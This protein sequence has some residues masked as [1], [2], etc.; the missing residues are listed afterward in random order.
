MHNQPIDSS[1]T[2]IILS[3]RAKSSSLL[4]TCDLASN[5]CA[6]CSDLTMVSRT[7]VALAVLLAVFTVT[8]GTFQLHGMPCVPCTS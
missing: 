1:S 6:L 3:S 5:E 7:V 2:L 8:E 4:F